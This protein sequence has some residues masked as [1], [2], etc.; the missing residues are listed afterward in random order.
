MTNHPVGSVTPRRTAWPVQKGGRPPGALSSGPSLGT[1][2]RHPGKARNLGYAPERHGAQ[3]DAATFTQTPGRPAASNLTAPGGAHSA[4]AWALA[5][6]AEQLG[7]GVA[8]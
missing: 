6:A 7:L 5:L 1:P 4:S 3:R 2:E 8:S